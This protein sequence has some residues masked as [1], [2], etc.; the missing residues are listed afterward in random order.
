[1]EK[2]VVK[3]DPVPENGAGENVVK[4]HHDVPERTVEDI[5]TNKSVET[6]EGFVT[7]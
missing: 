7:T 1:M 5:L 4:M 6:P 3:Q 2:E